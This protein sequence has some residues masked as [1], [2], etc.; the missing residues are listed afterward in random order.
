MWMGYRYSPA[1]NGTLNHHMP[2]EFSSVVALDG[3]AGEPLDILINWLLLLHIGESGG[4][5]DKYGVRNYR[6]YYAFRAY[7]SFESLNEKRISNRNPD[8]R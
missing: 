4:G 7:A 8:C 6:Y 2:C 1:N 3:L 5:G